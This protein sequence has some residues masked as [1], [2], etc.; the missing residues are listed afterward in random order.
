[1]LT[2]IFWNSEDSSLFIMDLQ[3]EMEEERLT[4]SAEWTETTFGSI[5]IG[6]FYIYI[7]PNSPPPSFFL[8]INVFILS[9]NTIPAMY[10]VTVIVVL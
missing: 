7:A 8:F 10:F 3:A 4:F 5:L 1:M 2:G 9:I 6:S